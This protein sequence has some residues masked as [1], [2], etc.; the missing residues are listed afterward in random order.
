MKEEAVK[1]IFRLQHSLTLLKWH[2]D[3]IAIVVNLKGLFS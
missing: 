1:N 3:V 2:M